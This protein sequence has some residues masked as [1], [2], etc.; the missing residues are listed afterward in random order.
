[1]VQTLR[2]L[3]HGKMF[4]KE[5]SPLPD[6]TKKPVTPAP[7]PTLPAY[8]PSA[9]PQ[10]GPSFQTQCASLS[11]HM[12]DKLRFLLF[13]IETVNICRSTISWTW[14]RGIQE[15]RT[16]AGSDELKMMGHP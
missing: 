6:E 12:E 16:Y 8:T 15:E 11:L 5:K 10:P 4:F 9:A 7:E 3:V 2:L 14:K 1:M 13:S